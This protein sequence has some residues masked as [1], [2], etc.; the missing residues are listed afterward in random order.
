MPI[1]LVHVIRNPYD[2][3]ASHVKHKNVTASDSEVFK[4][5]L[6]RYIYRI[7]TSFLL[8]LTSD[9]RFESQASIIKRLKA[10][11]SEKYPMIDIR[12]EDLIA[13][14]KKEI[15]RLFSFL[16]L[17]IDEKFLTDSAGIVFGKPSYSRLA[18][19]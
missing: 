15:Q 14:P 18:T 6:E 11:Q 13:D 5:F 16:E 19:F 9:S 10:E 8:V 17:P 7:H 3:M 12:S 4:Y 1:K 2:A